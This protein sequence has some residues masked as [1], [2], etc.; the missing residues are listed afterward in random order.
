MTPIA[1][2]VVLVRVLVLVVG[3][4]SQPIVNETRSCRAR[5][6]IPIDDNI[7]DQATMADCSFSP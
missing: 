7:L 6:R 1:T 4:V 2:I 5:K 3:V